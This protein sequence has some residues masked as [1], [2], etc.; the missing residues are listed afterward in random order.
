MRVV[1]RLSELSYI[2]YICVIYHAL[3]TVAENLGVHK[4]I[5][6]VIYIL[7]W[8]LRRYL[9]GIVTPNAT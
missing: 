3:P 6:I 2:Q 7:I 1:T 8:D 9:V 4:I 5:G